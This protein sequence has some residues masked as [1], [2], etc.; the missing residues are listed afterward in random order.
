LAGDVFAADLVELEARQQEI[1]NGKNFVHA[2]QHCQ[3]H[4]TGGEDT[5]YDQEKGRPGGSNED[6][7]GVTHARKSVPADRRTLPE[8][9]APS[10]T[11]RPMVR[12]E[13]KVNPTDRF[14]SN[15]S[16]IVPNA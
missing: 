15:Q 6:R 14:G 12:I 9:K 7:F 3:G 8:V 11:V 5:S 4:P 10:E 1:S 13:T 2:S 16:L